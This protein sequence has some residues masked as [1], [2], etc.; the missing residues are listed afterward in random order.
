MEYVL[1]LTEVDKSLVNGDPS[2]IRQILTNLVGNAIKFTEEGEIVVSASLT[3]LAN[4]RLAFQCMVSDTGIGIPANKQ[5]T[6]FDL[7]SQ[8]DA[9]TTRK[10]GGTGLGLSIVKKLCLMMGGDVEL[11][12]HEGEGSCFKFHIILENSDESKVIK[13]IHDISQMNILVVDDNPTNC[14]LVAKQISYWGAKVELS[15]SAEEVMRLLKERS[16]DKT[17]FLFDL[18]LV[19]LNMPGMN[20]IELAQ[21]I[22]VDDRLKVK[23]LVLMTPM[24]Y[25]ADSEYLSNVGFSSYFPKPATTLDLL[26]ALG[27]PFSDTLTSHRAS[28]TSEFDS[29][30]DAGQP[31]KLGLN[32][33]QWDSK[34]RILLV[35]DNQVNQEVARAILSEF[36]LN[37]DIAEDGQEA[38]DMLNISSESDPYSI[39]FMDCQM[40]RMDGYTASKLIR[41]GEAGK[42]YVKIPIVAITANAMKQDKEKCLSSGMDEYISKPIEP[43]ELVKKLLIWFKPNEHSVKK[44]IKSDKVKIMNDEDQNEMDEIWDEQA[45]LKRSLGKEKLMHSL[46]TMFLKSAPKQINDLELACEN[47]D[48]EQVRYL[49]HTIKGGAANLSALQVQ[50]VALR[51][52]ELAKQ[53]LC[54]GYQDIF[55][56]LKGHFDQVVDIFEKYVASKIQQNNQLEE[57]ADNDVL[58]ALLKTKLL[59]SDGAYI[60]PDE[61]SFCDEQFSNSLIKPDMKNLKD[62]ILQFDT[63]EA[64][65]LIGKIESKLSH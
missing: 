19:D 8:A 5:K 21:S 64:L 2:R 39:L 17:K 60:S 47:K 22:H 53:E 37:A 18:I 26:S 65:T 29:N 28:I 63:D 42:R 61:V 43:M 41:E 38:I 33:L 35:E 11:E 49:A 12:S 45:L 32:E 23:K 36:G 56:Q 44:S 14:R 20:G 9:S 40:P 30:S 7:F 6:L 4:G 15:N 3:K 52:E 13:P 27:T 54:E 59:L 46:I 50:N 57:M 62:L 25:K 10:Y 1:D 51:L 34:I 48:S 24:N 16:H 31:K 55:Q 58:D